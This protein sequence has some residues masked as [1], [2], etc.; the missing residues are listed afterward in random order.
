MVLQSKIASTVYG[1]WHR[2]KVRGRRKSGDNDT[3]LGNTRINIIAH[4]S[5][6]KKHG[7]RKFKDIFMMITGDDSYLIVCKN[8]V[9]KVFGSIAKMKRDLVAHMKG[10]GL[11]YKVDTANDP[12][13][14]EFCSSKMYPIGMLDY[15]IGKKPGRCL[16]KLGTYL[17][18][19]RT[20]NRSPEEWRQIIKG[21][22]LSYLPTAN[23][24]PFL[25]VYVRALLEE[26][27]HYEALYDE[28]T[29]YRLKGDIVEATDY[30][31][32]HFFV[33]YGL[34]TVEED[35]FEK[36]LRSNIK[37]YGLSFVCTDPYVRIMKDVEDAA[38][39]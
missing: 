1:T 25:R 16:C 6:F 31:W 37:K 29:F 20:M 23:H 33:V 17:S 22:L 21:T 34:T 35:I 19:Q 15:A 7:F 8:K 26:L 27:K 5:F 39:V 3:T 38:T 14:A 9:M 28:D 18:H 30:T 11:V 36:N 13:D 4:W 2:Y 32:A 24:V 12:T 10:N